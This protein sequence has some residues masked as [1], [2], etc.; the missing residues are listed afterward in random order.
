MSASKSKRGLSSLFRLGSVPG[1]PEEVRSFVARRIGVFLAASAVHWGGVSLLIL[2]TL[3]LTRPEDALLPDNRYRSAFLIVLAL[4]FA[5]LPYLLRRVE[6][7]LTRLA[8]VDIASTVAQG[9]AIGVMVLYSVPNVRFRP[10][11]TLILAL[12]YVLTAR[13]AVVPS[14]ASRTL[15]IS[16]MASAPVCAAVYQMHQ[17]ADELGMSLRHHY[18]DDRSTPATFFVW[19]CVFSGLSCALATF[20]SWIIFGL[21]REVATARQLG[22]YVLEQRIGA[23]GMGVV[24][25]ARHALLRR[26]TAVKLLP[27]ERAGALALARFER[28]VQATSQLSHPNIVS[29]YDYGRTP[30]GIFYY[31]MEY[32]EGIDLDQLVRRDGP[33]PPGRVAGIMRCVALALAEA[34]AHGLVHRDVKPSNVVLS[35]SA[36]G[37]DVIKV[38][39]F[40]LVRQIEPSDANLTGQQQFVG[41]PHY[42][43]PEQIMSPGVI[44]PRSD[45]YA[46][47]AVGYFLL[48]GRTLFDGETPVEICGHHLH[49]RPQAPSEVLASAVPAPL[50]QLI[51]ECLQKDAA[52][53]PPSAVAVAAL[54]DTAANDASWLP[55]AA[56]RWWDERGPSLREASAPA[57]SGAPITLAV[58]LE[59]RSARAR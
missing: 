57:N 34:H 14:T 16:L 47:G 49:T 50:E 58:N 15:M 9:V 23:G 25:R 44:D 36:L 19:A 31:A 35:R 30:E 12:T 39:D 1:S 29:I 43:A 4:A 26:P 13:A 17:I 24:Y 40:G 10:E 38:L 21:Q 59:D 55:E 7:G 56:G 41:T 3:L 11:F 42:M 52:R 5:S 33:Q 32:L 6:L 8:A 20:I 28:E 18:P 22:Q 46:L 54:L 53:R 2:P 51:L 45:L 37:G 27:P 48:T